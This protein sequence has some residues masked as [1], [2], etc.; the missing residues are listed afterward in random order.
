MVA[1][2]HARPHFG[3]DLVGALTDVEDVGRIVQRFTLGRGDPNDLLAVNKTIHTWSIILNRFHEERRLEAAER[4]G[5]DEASWASLDALMARMTDPHEL[6]KRI[7]MALED[8]CVAGSEASTSNNLESS[9]EDKFDNVSPGD[10]DSI[11]W[12]YGSVKWTIKPG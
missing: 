5:L 3:A 9:N 6:S 2:F 12:R 1:F 8:E 11:L 7:S 10:G 4:S